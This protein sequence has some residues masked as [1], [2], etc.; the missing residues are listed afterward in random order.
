MCIPYVSSMY[1]DYL[2]GYMYAA[3]ILH[4]SRMSPSYQIRRSLDAFEIHV[5]HDVFQVYS[6]CILITSADTCI[7]NISRMYLA[8]ILHL[9]YVPH[10]DTFEVCVSDCIPHVS[11]PRYMY[12]D[13]VSRCILM[14][15]DEESKIHVS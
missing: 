8:C 2:L 12:R 5:S 15:R 11:R 3:C 13:F 7:P 4:V 10:L 6:A 14:Y 1:L 9:S